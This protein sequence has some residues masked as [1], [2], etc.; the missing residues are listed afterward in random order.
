VRGTSK[1]AHVELRTEGWNLQ[2]DKVD[3]V[4]KGGGQGAAELHPVQRPARIINPGH[5]VDP[6]TNTRYCRPQG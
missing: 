1:A 4:G 3:E 6:A 2:V 5:R